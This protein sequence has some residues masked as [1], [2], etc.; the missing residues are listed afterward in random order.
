MEILNANDQLNQPLLSSSNEINK[1][2]SSNAHSLP[3]AVWDESKK[4][5]HIVGPTIVSRVS[6]ATMNVVTQA[7]AGHLGDL[8]LASVS[9]ANN[10]I[11][12]FNWGLLRARDAVRASVRREEVQHAGDIHAEIVHRSVP[13]LLPA[14][15]AVRFRD[16]ATEADRAAGRRGGAGGGGGGVADPAALQLRVPVPAAEILAEPA[17]NGAADVGAAGGAGHPWVSQL[18][19]CDLENWYYRILIVMTGFFDNAKIAVDALSICMTINSWEMMFSLAFFAGVGVRVANELGAGNGRSAK[20]ATNVCVVQS[21]A[22]GLFFFAIVLIFRGKLALIF[23]PSGEVV[24]AVDALSFLLAFSVLLNSVQP[25]L[26]GVA[27]GS[28][29][30]AWVAWINIFCYYII[31]L[32]IGAVLGWGFDWGTT[33]EKATSRVEEWSISDMESHRK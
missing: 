23:S 31:G 5:W 15:P 10:V 24:A 17:E 19:Y 28:G 6:N 30:Q 14:P 12:G 1:N 18:D 21:T 4:L 8:E 9:I 25:V 2:D 20:V 27:V 13:V 11:V 16:A 32:P 33:V 7:F 22:I 3:A 26:S 29:W